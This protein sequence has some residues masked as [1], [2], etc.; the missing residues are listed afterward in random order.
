MERMSTVPR[1][2]AFEDEKEILV[3]FS[4]THPSFTL[5]LNYGLY[6][7]IECIGAIL[8]MEACMVKGTIEDFGQSMRD[9]QQG[10]RRVIRLDKEARVSS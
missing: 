10:K 9:V 7:K 4:H 1:Q 8:S 6:L 3:H 5:G 2:T